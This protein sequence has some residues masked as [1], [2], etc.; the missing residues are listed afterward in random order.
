MTIDTC[1]Q[2]WRP[3]VTWQRLSPIRFVAFQYGHLHDKREFNQLQPVIPADTSNL[4]LDLFRIKVMMSFGHIVGCVKLEE[5]ADAAGGN[6]TGRKQRSERSQ[7][8][9]GCESQSGAGLTS[10]NCSSIFYR[11]CISVAA[12]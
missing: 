10:F 7:R 11:Y 5:T 9:E 2:V 6:C 12:A 3:V 4:C 8:S 1:G